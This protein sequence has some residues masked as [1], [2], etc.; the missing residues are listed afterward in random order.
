MIARVQMCALP[1]NPYADQDGPINWDSIEATTLLDRR[2]GR[3]DGQ[4]ILQCSAGGATKAT[5]RSDGY[6]IF[7]A[8]RPAS[9]ATLALPSMQFKETAQAL[10]G[11]RGPPLVL[12]MRAVHAVRPSG[13]ARAQLRPVEGIQELVTERFEVVTQRAGRKADVL[14][15]DTEVLAALY[16]PCVTAHGPLLTM[17]RTCA[18]RASHIITPPISGQC[19]SP[20]M[21]THPTTWCMS[22]SHPR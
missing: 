5:V 2:E 15:P 8:S 12:A 3:G 16:H 21:R 7:P 6:V 18:P 11:G 13:G 14:M 17:P 19:L 4:P 10:L 9:A 20:N 1:A 22:L